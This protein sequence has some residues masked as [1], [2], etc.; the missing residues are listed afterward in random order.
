MH[1]ARCKCPASVL[2]LADE[3]LDL[4][5]FIWSPYS[6]AQISVGKFLMLRVH[7]LCFQIYVKVLPK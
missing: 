3:R 7:S 2:T 4:N 5:K 1:Q 6:C